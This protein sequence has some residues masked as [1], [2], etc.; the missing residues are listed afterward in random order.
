MT[1]MVVIASSVEEWKIVPSGDKLEILAITDD[2]MA[3]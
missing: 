2:I 1:V 3:I